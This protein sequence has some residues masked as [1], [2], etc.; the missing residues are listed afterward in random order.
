MPKFRYAGP[1]EQVFPQYIDTERGSTLVA[2]AGKTYDIAIADG[3]DG[4][5]AMP[6]ND[7]FKPAA[8][9]LSSSG[10]N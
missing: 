9:A 7:D 5:L 8:K 1:A 3:H 6:P 4:D 10:S 2:A